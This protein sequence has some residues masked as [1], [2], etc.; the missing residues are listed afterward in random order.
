MNENQAKAK[1]KEYIRKLSKGLVKSFCYTILVKRFNL[2]TQEAI[3]VC[4]ELVSEGLLVQK[5][6]VLCYECYRVMDSYVEGEKSKISFPYDCDLCGFEHEEIEDA[7]EKS[8]S[9]QFVKKGA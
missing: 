9:Y 6:D 3:E 2:S 4:K 8:D 5:N 1:A 7:L